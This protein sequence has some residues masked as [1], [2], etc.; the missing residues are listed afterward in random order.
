MKIKEGGFEFR[1]DPEGTLVFQGRRCLGRIITMKEASGRYCFRLDCDTR[2][3]PRTY[4]GR[5]RAATALKVIDGLKRQA[6]KEKWSTELLIVKSWD[7][8]P[9]TA[10]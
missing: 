3:H 7:E 9:H 2:R 8:K 5:V 6:E 10:P 1:D 4:R